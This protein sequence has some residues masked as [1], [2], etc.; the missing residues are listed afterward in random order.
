MEKSNLRHRLLNLCHGFHNQ[1]HSFCN[2]CHRF[3]YVIH[4]KPLSAVAKRGFRGKYSIISWHAQSLRPI[5]NSTKKATSRPMP[6]KINTHD[7][8]T[9]ERMGCELQNSAKL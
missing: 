4:K 9:V 8:Y 2:Q 5:F 6:P 3:E 1:R 7:P